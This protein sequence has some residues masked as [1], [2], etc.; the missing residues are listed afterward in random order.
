MNTYFFKHLILL[1]LQVNGKEFV[2]EI[3]DSVS[4]YIELMKSIFDFP[5]LKNLLSANAAKP[6]RVLINSM[7]GG[8]YFY[9]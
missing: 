8:W 5:K 3:I 4:D 2:V 1:Y 6:F 9:Q 7:H